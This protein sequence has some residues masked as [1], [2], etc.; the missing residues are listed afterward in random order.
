[1][2]DSN[3]CTVNTSTQSLSVTVNNPPSVTLSSSA[4]EEYYCEAGTVTFTASSPDVVTLYQWFVDGAPYVN[5][6]PTFSLAPT[7]TQTVTVRITNA[8]GC[9]ATNSLTLV[10][11][12]VI[13]DGN[14]ELSNP[15]DINVC[16]G[17]TPLGSIG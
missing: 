4:P 2:I 8:S 7:G 10:E 14:I 13:D 11:L 5:N 1:M 17:N 16:S 9:T 6:N 3:G 12:S 15:L